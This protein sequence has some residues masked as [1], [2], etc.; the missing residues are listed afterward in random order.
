MAQR[1]PSMGKAGGAVVHFIA[2][3]QGPTEALSTGGRVML[4]RQMA[5]EQEAI[6]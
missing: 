3:A 1:D 2:V 6:A 4:A 5:G